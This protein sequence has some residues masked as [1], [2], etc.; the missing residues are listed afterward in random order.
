MASKAAF[1]GGGVAAIIAAV[2][3]LEGG[4]VNDPA[5]PGG[6]TNHGITKRVAET[7]GYKGSMRD[8]P[9]NLVQDIYL[10]DYI[11]KPGFMPMV[12][13]QPAVATKLI[14]AGVNAGPYRSSVW[15]QQSLNALNRGGKDF[16]QIYVDGRV[17]PSTVRTY[18]LL[19]KVRGKRRAC[20]LVLKAMDGF[21][22]AHYLS[23]T[24]LNK[25]TV[26]WLDT[27]IGNVPIAQCKEWS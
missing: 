12:E 24:K 3:A 18:V 20:E 19:E 5:D 23:L 25:F 4:Y 9:A 17:G 6:E 1:A 7:H 11:E 27:R 21:Q 10:K 16:P 14:D 15:F 8:I 2:L 26:G 22:A 13:L